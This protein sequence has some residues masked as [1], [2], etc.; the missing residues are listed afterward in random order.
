MKWLF[1]Y[2]QDYGFYIMNLSGRLIW[3]GPHTKFHDDHFRHFS[4]SEVTT[5]TI[6][7]ASMLVLP[8]EGIYEVAV[9]VDSGSKI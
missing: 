6:W 8:M 9:R 1:R 5:S 4:N 2:D 3:H 7:E